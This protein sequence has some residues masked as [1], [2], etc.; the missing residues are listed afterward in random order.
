[1]LD[2]SKRLYDKQLDLDFDML[3]G[4]KENLKNSSY[5]DGLKHVI[6]NL[7]EN[8]PK[9]RTSLSAMARWL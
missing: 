1:M 5:S 3:K 9:K 6:L 8:E 2:T 7:I 4:S